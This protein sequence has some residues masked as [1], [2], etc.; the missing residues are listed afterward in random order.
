M[1]Q[2]LRAAYIGKKP[3]PAMIAAVRAV[4]PDN[5]MA[6]AILAE[7][8]LLKALDKL[9]N[10]EMAAMAAASEVAYRFA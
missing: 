4:H 6:A 2:S 9:S 7:L 5:R 1:N 3:H 8:A 10:V